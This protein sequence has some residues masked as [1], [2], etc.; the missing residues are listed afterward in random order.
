MP[1]DSLELLALEEAYPNVVFFQRGCTALSDANLY[2][3]I[4]GK[5]SYS[6]HS[7][8]TVRDRGILSTGTIFRKSAEDEQVH[9]KSQF[10][11]AA[12]NDSKANLHS[13]LRLKTQVSIISSIRLGPPVTYLFFFC[14]G[15]PGL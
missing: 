1:Q 14:S 13:D 7:K 11:T 4:G 3:Q 15:I 5:S 12:T 9:I 10:R 6:R 2:A 8:G